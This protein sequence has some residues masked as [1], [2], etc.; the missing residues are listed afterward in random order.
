[1]P[2]PVHLHQAR[3]RGAAGSGDG[4]GRARTGCKEGAMGPV[5]LPNCLQLKRG[6][7]RTARVALVHGHQPALV[8]HSTIGH[9]DPYAPKRRR[10]SQWMRA[11]DAFAAIVRPTGVDA[12]CARWLSRQA[13]AFAAS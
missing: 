3:E 5:A 8:G 10:R 1:G 2:S 7:L 12:G 13:I 9:G 6:L 4:A 11:V